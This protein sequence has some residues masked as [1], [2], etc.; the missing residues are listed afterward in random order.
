M[1]QLLGVAR[2][3]L[4]YH[5][6]RP[7][8]YVF[9]FVMALLGFF[10]TATDAATFGGATGKVMRNAPWVISRAVMVLTL[11]G[12]MF[13]SAIAGSA[14]LRDFELKAH[15]LLFTTRLRKSSF[16]FGRF[17]GAYAVTLLVL[18][19]SALG[20]WVGSLMPWLDP[21]K[22][23]PTPAGTYLW[24][25]AV[26]VAPTALLVSA[27][28]FAVGVLTRSFLAVS[29]QGVALVVG[30]LIASTVI[31]D[32]ESESMSAMLDPFALNATA[33]V[34]RY[35]TVAE[36][37]GR[38]F[39]PDGLWLANRA[40][41][42]GV[43]GLALLGA[44]RLFRME[45]FARKLG[46]AR[47]AEARAP[48]PAGGGVLPTVAPASGA[49]VELARLAALVRLYYRDVVRDR[50]F[51]ALVVV[52]MGLTLFQAFYADLLY[53]T[54]VYPV[55]YA[56]IEVI[57]GFGLFYLLLTAFYSG[58]LIWRERDLLCDQV[59][60]ATPTGTGTIFAGKVGALL[61]VHATLLAPLILTGVLV[62]AIKGY[63]QFELDVYFGYLYGLVLPSVALTAIIAFFL[64]VV[65]NNKY[66]GVG[67]VIVY[68]I[69]LLA[70]G[71]LGVTDNLFIP[72]GFNTPTFSAMNR[73]GPDLG[74]WAWFHLY[75]FAFAAVLLVVARLLLVR[76]RAAGWRARLRLAR[77]RVTGRWLAAAAACVA[78]WLG[79]FFFIRHNTHALNRFRGKDEAE[80][81]QAEYERSFKQYEGLPQ[82]RIVGVDVK[83]DLDPRA[84]HVRA[85]GSYALVNKTQAPIERVHLLI[86]EEVTISSLA[87]EG[88][89]EIELDDAR[90]RYQIHRLKAPLGPG[91]ATTLRFELGDLREGFSNAGRSTAVVENGSFVQSSSLL[92]TIG[93]NDQ[94]ELTDDDERKEQGLPPR[95][96]MH[97]LE[98][99]AARRNNYIS[100]DADWI[101]FKATACTDPD[102]IAL[103]P[104]YLQREYEEGGRRCFVYAMD[105]KILHFFSVLSARYAVK[106]DAWGDVAIE[107]YYHPGHEYNVDRMI[108]AVKKSLDY[109]TANFSPYQH[110]QVR[111]LEFPRYASFAQ[112]FPNTIPY[113]ESIGFIARVR[114]DDPEDIDYPFY[115]TAHEV[116]HQWWA[117]QVIGANVQGATMMSESLAQYSAL[118]VLEKEIGPHKM[119]KFLEYELKG[120]LGGRSV[121]RKKELPLMRNENQP[122]I[123]YQ[124]GSLVFYALR[125]Y[126]GEATLNAALARY[127]KQVGFQEPPYTTSRE[128]VEILREATPPEYRYVI[129]DMLETITLYDNKVVSATATPAGEGKTKV[130]FTV[131][132][133]KLRADELGDETEV[134][135]ADSID[136]GVFA[137]PGPGEHELGAPLLLEK[138]RITGP[139]T[140]IEVEVAGAP[141]RVG[142]DPYNKL[143]DRSPRDNT[144][145]L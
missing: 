84:G 33:L 74:P 27:I 15:E 3:E 145:G 135:I 94:G 140:T 70:M 134:P 129:E 90:F 101:D 43:A 29:V 30:Y 83:V 116:A 113:S 13:V 61:L 40:L 58:A 68:Y 41:W 89:S 95:E 36:K 51:I 32:L 21:E 52:G 124:K 109:F 57:S 11:V 102:Q 99:E 86:P 17:L 22:F 19:A 8:T 34:E 54:T 144:M 123:H 50:P 105:A 121:E 125:D 100:G 111:I 66:L 18:S 31:D 103:A 2:F 63:T 92:P 14:I 65:A 64:H 24:P 4:R 80:A 106:R 53:G 12:T 120:Y 128:L 60:D 10:I 119:K 77:G 137:A 97:A 107:V 82:P 23:G 85:A 59:S 104:G 91:A 133:K 37:N 69:A 62:Q 108:E 87:F 67:L 56:M 88:G 71:S 5:L 44:Y 131:T 117:H 55:T 49:R 112:S 16:V 114:P 9:V 115:V 48:E 45:S 25:I 76:G 96:R 7:L 110:R 26:H 126:L 132:A 38:L 136:V 118:M 20:M 142:I 141:A 79:L 130:V 47:P 98:D 139:E 42:L 81:L 127:I 138:R 6:R 122:Y 39:A 78:L 73:Y 28:F 46:R 143:I 35:W 93:Y 1:S 75:Y 72:G